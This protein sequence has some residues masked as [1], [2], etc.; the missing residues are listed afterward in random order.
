M[1]GPRTGESRRTSHQKNEFLWWLGVFTEHSSDAG[2]AAEASGD[3]RYHGGA[4]RFP[5]VPF[6]RAT[7]HSS[8]HQVKLGIDPTRI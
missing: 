4:S 7:V 5:I 3:T 6:F 8:V 1:H 2:L